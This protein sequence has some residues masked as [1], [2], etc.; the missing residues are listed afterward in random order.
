MYPNTL[1][2]D[3]V[4]PGDDPWLLRLRRGLAGLTPN[5]QVPGRAFLG[6][7][8]TQV[9][10]IR[11]LMP[12][13]PTVAAVL[14][15][16]IARPTGPTLLFTERAAAL[17]RHSGQISFPGG[18]PE[19]TDTSATAGAL[20]ESGE[21]IG[22]PE[23]AVEVLG[24]LPEQIILTGFRVTPVVGWV[25][26]GW[27]LRPDPK[28]VADVFEVPL[29]FLLERGNR[30]VC[31]RRIGDEIE[32]ELEEFHWQG[33]RIWGATAEMVMALAAL[34]ETSGD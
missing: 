8:E 34:L 1:S 20:R 10:R 18:R 30:V 7:P 28:E 5:G 32:V 25:T 14:M 22:L 29:E 19:A 21:E 13:N 27:P 15:P 26:P 4:S 12:P 16:V 11:E 2:R 3:F 17:R 24:H 9:A 23:T 33:R 31:R 6:L